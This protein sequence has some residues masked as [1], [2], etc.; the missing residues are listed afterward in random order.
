MKKIFFVFGGAVCSLVFLSACTPKKTELDRGKT[1]YAFHC[2]S[3]H[4]V[5]GDGKGPVA[6]YLFPKPRD[7]TSGIF[8]YR[9]TR[10]PIPGDLD[11]L[12]TVKMGIP[13]S[14]MP[15]WDMLKMEDW[16]AL[17]AAVKTFLPRLAK[18]KAG[19]S[20]DIPE[21][22]KVTAEAVH[23]GRELFEKTGCIAC[24]GPQARGDGPAAGALK[25]VWG[26][27][28]LPR[29]LTQGP[30]KWGNGSKEIYRTLSLGIPGTPMPSY[31]HTF[32]PAQLW[33]LVHYIKSLQRKMPEGYDPSNPKRNLL[34]VAKTSGDI[35]L[36]Y[37]ASAWL[38]PTRVPVFLKPLWFDKNMTEWLNVK[39]LYNDKE[40]AFYLSWADDQS[41]SGEK[42]D[43]VAIQFPLRKIAEASDL[44][45]LGMGHFANA[46]QIW[47]WKTGGVSKLESSGVGTQKPQSIAANDLMAYGIYQKGYWHV[48]LKRPL[49]S[50]LDDVR[51]GGS[52]G[53]LSFA[54][55]DAD[56]ARHAGPEAFSEWMIYEL[57]SSK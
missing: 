29:D 1:L 13:G 28:V 50:G 54:L 8:K 25:D 31:E 45:Y 23:A 41:N 2:A 14:A 7:L 34:Q 43:G 26:E 21:E 15:G 37:Q 9:S 16:R 51:F 44:P 12:Q 19:P 36:D 3:C 57:Q 6:Q 20:I 27:P 30:L 39:A 5:K 11:I 22:P 35:P 48:I 53:F 56:L 18:S 40:I 55:W 42:S 32:T 24:H 49:V 17:L 52:T 38:K 10:G 33:H 47:N 4:G 46:V